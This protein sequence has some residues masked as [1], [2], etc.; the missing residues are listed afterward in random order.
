MRTKNRPVLLVRAIDSVVQQRHQNWQL[1]IVNDGGDPAPVEAL[2]AAVQPEQR[3][4]I[5]ILHHPQSL[6]M[7]AA[8]NAGLRALQTD[9]VMVHDDDDSL[10]ADFFRADG[11]LPGQSSAWLSA[12][13]DYWN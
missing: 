4:R 11:R 13:S 1:V 12:W 7:E 6:G 8:S 2:V 5:Q 9:Y 3:A 10:H